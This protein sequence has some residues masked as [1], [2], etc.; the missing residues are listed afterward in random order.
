MRP[1]TVRKYKS[2][3]FLMWSAERKKPEPQRT[4][5]TTPSN[6]MRRG[7]AS[8]S[9]KDRISLI[10]FARRESEQLGKSDR[11][12]SGRCGRDRKARHDLRRILDREEH[13]SKPR[14]NNV[15]ESSSTHRPTHQKGI[16]RAWTY[17]RVFHFKRPHCDSESLRSF[18]V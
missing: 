9:E 6:T 1:A 7:S 2:M 3:Q 16:P 5:G 18:D 8:R 13:V 14:R 4:I 11:I 12:V 17:A 10:Y 15:S